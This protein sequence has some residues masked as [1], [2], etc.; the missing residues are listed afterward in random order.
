MQS[1]NNKKRKI[2]TANSKIQFHVSLYP[3]NARFVSKANKKLRRM[4]E[5]V[6]MDG[7]KI[8]LEASAVFFHDFEFKFSILVFWVLF[9]P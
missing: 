1:N 4:G 3:M 5:W 8:Q 6:R 7:P 2:G 9:I